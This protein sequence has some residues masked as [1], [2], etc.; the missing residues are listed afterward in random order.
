MADADSTVAP[1]SNARQR[2][3]ALTIRARL[4]VLYTGLFAACGAIVVAI[5]YGL[6]A[7]SLTI[8]SK[9]VGVSSALADTCRRADQTHTV[10]ADLKAKCSAAYQEGVTAGVQSQ[11]DATLH[12]LL[13][14]SVLTLA[15]VT[16][17][18]AVAGWLV[19][20]R[21]LRPVHRI[22]AAARAA[23]ENNLGQRVGLTGPRDELRELADTFDDMLARLDVAFASQR[24]FI[25]N[26]SHELRT[27]LTVMRTSIDVV[28]G[29]PAPTAAELVAMGQEVRD[30]V[31]HAE[32]V[33]DALLT[34][35]H[36]ARGL[37]KREPVDLATIAEDVLDATAAPAVRVEAS[38]HPAEATGDATLLERLVV[39][40]VDNA[41]RY[42][43]PG[44]RLW[45]R[46]GTRAGRAWLEV[47]NTGPAIPPEEVAGL[48]EP[49]RRLHERTGADGVGLGL[50]LVA[51]IAAVH[52]G[53][54]TAAARRGGGLTVT[55]TLTAT[56]VTL[57]A[58]VSP[59][60][61]R[62]PRTVGDTGIEPATSPI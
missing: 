3:P 16:V 31:D 25:A 47:A 62:V 6:V 23:S 35:A 59:P 52:G 50:A 15:A 32:G 8:T 30:A 55:I 48:F 27:P 37:A 46:T 26:A 5:T 42:N 11:R 29:K 51:S 45:L 60:D 13:S 58:P 18:A 19:A 22:T 49:F 12:H 56:P 9:T 20:G 36:N 43:V 2:R 7:A 39:N 10:N 24:Q 21:V 33:I 1:R 53:T 54:A 28:L 57:A 44:G 41:I 38:L 17:L 34:L 14:Y 4:T 61:A 40:L